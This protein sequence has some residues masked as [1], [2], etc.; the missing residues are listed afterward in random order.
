MACQVR[1]RRMNHIYYLSDN[2]DT[3]ILAARATYSLVGRN[4]L[5]EKT[6]ASMAVSGGHLFIRTEK[7]LYCIGP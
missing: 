3:T 2:G 6:Q 1:F 7:N 4:K 5:G